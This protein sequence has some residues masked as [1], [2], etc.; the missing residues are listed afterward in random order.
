MQWGNGKPHPKI[1]ISINIKALLSP[2]SSQFYL[3]TTLNCQNQNILQ[4]LNNTTVM[5]VGSSVI[6]IHPE[7]GFSVA[8]NKSS[9]LAC[10]NTIKVINIDC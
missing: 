6:T 3:R 1:T 4:N 2:V 8:K 9:F 5:N 7:R 10:Q